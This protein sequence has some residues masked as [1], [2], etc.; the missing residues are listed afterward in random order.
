MLFNVILVQ[1]YF[2]M[3]AVIVDK[4]IVLEP[5]SPLQAPQLF[6]AINNNRKEFSEFLPWV[7]DMRTVADLTDYLK[8]AELSCQQEK[9]AS[10][11]ILFDKV[12]VGRIGIHH[13]NM[14]NKV[15]T[16]GYWLSKDAQ[17]KGIMLKSCIAIINFG[18][19]NLG[20]HRIEI[21]AAIS[22]LKSQAIPV[23]LNF[24][25][26]GILRQAEF[27]NNQFLD[28]FLYSMISDD[29]QKTGFSH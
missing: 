11:A 24:V 13:L 28:L 10:F 7:A 17:G 1:E 21:K 9:E 29:W 15:G 27:V 5:T 2:I 12:A 6:A 16:I 4:N 22:N 14:P 25:K 3:N 23:K 19:E 18:F 20:L 8:S 26:E